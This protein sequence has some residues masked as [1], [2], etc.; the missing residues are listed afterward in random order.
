MPR[1]NGDWRHDPTLAAPTNADPNARYVPP[2]DPWPHSGHGGPGADGYDHRPARDG[3]TLDS[4]QAQDD[5]W[6]GSAQVRPPVVPTST[7]Q[8][9]MPPIES[10]SPYAATRPHRPAPYLR[11]GLPRP[12]PPR[13]WHGG[14]GWSI[15]GAV[16]AFLCWGVWAASERGA[17]QGFEVLISLGIVIAVAVGV[18]IVSRLIGRVVIEGW[19]GRVRRTARL[20]HLLV[21]AFLVAAGVSYLRM[22]SWVVTA[23]HWI[24]G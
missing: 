5:V 18:F 8:E 11:P 24:N 19:S 21:F 22:T 9:S 1:S 3:H 6:R 16:F 23:F 13:T 12:K 7:E 20:S 14:G 2:S 17:L 4:A 15:F 10:M